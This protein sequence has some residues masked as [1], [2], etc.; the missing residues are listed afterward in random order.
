M[1]NRSTI[2]VSA[3]RLSCAWYATKTARGR[4][5]LRLAEVT[6]IVATRLNLPVPIAHDGMAITLQ[7]GLLVASEDGFTLP[8]PRCPSERM[9]DTPSDASMRLMLGLVVTRCRPAWAAVLAMPPQFF[10]PLLPP[11]TRQC[12][13]HAGV[14]SDM[15]LAVSDWLDALAREIEKWEIDELKKLGDVGE[16]L[17]LAVERT[18]LR[19][20]DREDLADQV[21]RVSLESD[22][23]GYDIRSFVGDPSAARPSDS[24]VRIEVKATRHLLDG[25]HRF[26]LTRNEW[27]AANEDPGSY[28]IHLWTIGNASLDRPEGRL[29]GVLSVRDLAP[30]LPQNTTTSATWT[31]SEVYWPTSE[32]IH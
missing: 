4:R 3:G 17:S 29:V 15:S 31:E 28:E 25:K 1:H 18:R 5:G 32:I 12:F 16:E 9:P 7:T 30:L 22:S 6:R 27:R 8:G 13:E 26:F 20:L 2:P 21:R 19:S 14:A 24:V 10:M 11:D 23:Y